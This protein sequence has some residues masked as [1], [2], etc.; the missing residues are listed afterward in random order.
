MADDRPAEDPVIAL[1]NLR[2]EF[3]DFKTSTAAR[4]VRWPTGTIEPT[5]LLSAKTNTLLL[6]GQTIS[7]TTYANLWLWVSENGLSPSVFGAGDGSTTFMLPDLRGKAM[8]GGTVVDPVGKS[9][10]SA[11]VTLGENHIP[12][13]DHQELTG[14]GGDHDH[15]GGTG[16]GGNHDGHVRDVYDVRGASGDPPH[17]VIWSSAETRG[18]DSGSHG[19]GIG[20]SGSHKH[21]I[22]PYGSENPDPI[23]L[24]QPSYAVNFL[25]WT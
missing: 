6:H 4:L 19:H 15:G 13:H 2:K 20:G 17:Y 23:F 9:F 16:S 11:S 7:R 18:V 1:A 3:E 5:F 21:G 10:G 22:P 25:I 24:V 12:W 14:F 8:V